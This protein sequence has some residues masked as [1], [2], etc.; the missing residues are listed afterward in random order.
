MIKTL[1][2]NVCLTHNNVCMDIQIEDNNISMKVYKEGQHTNTLH[3]DTLDKE[4]E[5]YQSLLTKFGLS[6]TDAKVMSM[7]AIFNYTKT[8]DIRIILPKDAY[9]NCYNKLISAITNKD[10]SIITKEE[11]EILTGKLDITCTYDNYMKLSNEEKQ[12]YERSL[13]N[14]SKSILRYHRLIAKLLNNYKEFADKD[15]TFYMECNK[16]KLEQKPYESF[17]VNEHIDIEHYNDLHCNC[18]SFKDISDEEEFKKIFKGIDMSKYLKQ[19]MSLNKL[20]K[21]IQNNIKLKYTY[22][23]SGD[24]EKQAVRK[25]AYHLIEN[26]NHDNVFNNISDDYLQI[27]MAENWLT[28]EN[29]NSVNKDL[30]NLLYTDSKLDNDILKQLYNESNNKIVCH[31]DIIDLIIRF[32]KHTTEDDIHY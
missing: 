6:E 9:D 22:V 26:F 5:Y 31:T 4:Q 14:Y 30:Y 1:S 21:L 11:L 17:H 15:I 29:E 8:D 27:I 10:K 3:T 12:C 2:A 24:K 28:S 13:H 23:K 20:K 19:T 16:L 25:V 32:L 18:L 7:F